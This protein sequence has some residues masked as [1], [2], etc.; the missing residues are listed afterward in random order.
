MHCGRCSNDQSAKLRDIS[1]CFA[2]LYHLINVIPADKDGDL[3]P[4]H[5]RPASHWVLAQLIHLNDK[6][7]YG[8]YKDRE[9]TRGEGICSHDM[10]QCNARSLHPPFLLLT[11]VGHQTEHFEARV[12]CILRP[13]GTGTILDDIKQSVSCL[14]RL[15]FT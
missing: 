15:I 2:S 14:I 3:D 1:P 5:V 7:P 4:V 11:F 8:A 12:A 6:Y 10:E 13:F 9:P